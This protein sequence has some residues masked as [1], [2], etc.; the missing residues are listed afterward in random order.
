MIKKTREQ[1][2]NFSIKLK[3]KID[4]FI[5]KYEYDEEYKIIFKEYLVKMLNKE[6]KIFLKSSHINHIVHPIANIIVSS[7]CSNY[8][9]QDVLYDMKMSGE[10]QV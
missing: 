8:I 9:I 10:Y 7:G 6:L 2:E 4:K 1:E 5:L 3:N